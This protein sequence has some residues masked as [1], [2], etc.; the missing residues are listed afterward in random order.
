MCLSFLAQFI[1]TPV[2][3]FSSFCPSVVPSVYTIYMGK[4]KYESKYINV[5]MPDGLDL[6]LWGFKVILKGRLS[7]C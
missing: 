4:D 6:D 2:D 7:M 3:L 1:Q 5:M